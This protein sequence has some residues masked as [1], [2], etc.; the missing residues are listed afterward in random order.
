[1][2][3]PDRLIA[4]IRAFEQGDPGAVLDQQALVEADAVLRQATDADSG[5]AFAAVQVVAWLRW[6]RYLAL[7]E[8]GDQDDLLAAIELFTPI[9]EANPQAVPEPVRRYLAGLAGNS[10]DPN[11]QAQV[12][13]ALLQRAM[14][15]DDP[16][17]LNQAIEL[18]TAA[19]AATP[20]DHPDHAMYL[21][22]LGLALL[23]RFER[24]GADADLD[25]AITVG[26]QAVAAT[27]TDHP[28]HAGMLSNLG[29]AL[30]TRFGRTGAG[31]DL[32]EAITVIRQAVAATPTDH[33]DHAGY[34]SNLG[35]AL[36]T[37]FGRTGAGADLDE[38]ITLGRA[39]L[40]ATPTDH[41]DHA[42]YLS[43][44][45][46]T[47]QTRFERTGAD[48]DLDEAITVGRAVAAATPTD[49]PNRAG[50]LSNLGAALSTRFGRTGAGADLDEAVT[51]IRQAV[52][53]TP[54]DHPK[55][56]GDLSNLGAALSTRFGR[57]GAGAD[58]DEAVTVGQQ[59]VTATPTDHPDRAMHL[60]D[61]GVALRIRFERTEAGADLDEAVWGWSRACESAVAPTATRLNAARYWAQAIARWR[62]SAAAVG[63]YTAALNLLPLLAWR[64]IGHQDQQHLLQAHAASLGRDGAACA[65]AAGRLDLAVELVEQGRGVFW[66]QLLD[67]RTDLTALRQA[68]P[69]LAEQLQDCRALLEQPI[70]SE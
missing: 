49:H 55:R 1:M 63:A 51:V 41:P 32:D 5:S 22:I 9:A 4:R 40:A 54:T 38:A 19:V 24:S 64:G 34:L 61:L 6:C 20:T 13:G 68:A 60:F 45:G 35:A 43:N 10:A 67:T 29:I 14:H 11:Q 15:S 7:P 69:D 46:S 66:S 25:E 65:I 16:A 39:A 48:A 26:R 50:Y 27:S 56:A 3:L 47:L 62:G 23:T 30:R 8:G 57:T 58:L 37:R 53:A 44:L 70:P 31:A 52:A 21:S 18:L 42:G 17:A 28:D 2:S 36:R 12:A 59:A 33:P